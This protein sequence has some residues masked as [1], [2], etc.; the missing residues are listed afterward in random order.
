MGAPKLGEGEAGAGA[1]V[2]FQYAAN[3][4]LF[5]PVSIIYT[6][7]MYLGAEWLDSNG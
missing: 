1:N 2:C 7:W 4:G 3:H 6:G 5:F